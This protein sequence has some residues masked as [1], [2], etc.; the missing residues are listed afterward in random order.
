MVFLLAGCVARR[1]A[2]VA[3]PVAPAMEAERSTATPPADRD[4]LIKDYRA[5]KDL[6]VSYDG[7]ARKLQ[8]ARAQ[9]VSIL[10]RNRDYA[11]AYVGMAMIEAVMLPYTTIFRPST[12][13]DEAGTDC[14]TC[15]RSVMRFP[16]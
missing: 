2:P 5:A 4:P 15:T 7:D 6:I 8:Q 12:S 10:G 14:E 1:E 13:A 3:E 11:P 16:G 9:L